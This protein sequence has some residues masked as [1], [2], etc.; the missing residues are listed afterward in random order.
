MSPLLFPHFIDCILFGVICSAIILILYPV[1]L[2][3]TLKN[4]KFKIESSKDH[5]EF[6]KAN[7]EHTANALNKYLKFH[8][9]I[10]FIVSI[11]LFT[12][13]L[14]YYYNTHAYMFSPSFSIENNLQQSL[15][16]LKFSD[17]SGWYMAFFTLNF[18]IVD[19]LLYVRDGIRIINEF[20]KLKN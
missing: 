1:G 7:Y 19:I 15:N 12:P 18:I 5:K 2:F 10:F 13:I 3:L 17:D 9:P 4:E 8:L 6:N 11:A 14:W 20:R 16:V